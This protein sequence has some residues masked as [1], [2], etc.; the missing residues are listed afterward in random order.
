[1]AAYFNIAAASDR[2][3]GLSARNLWYS[4]GRNPRGQHWLHFGSALYSVEVFHTVLY[5]QPLRRTTLKTALGL[6]AS[7]AGDVGSPGMQP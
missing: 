4:T 3:G 1:M 6:P 7:P 2:I 5:R